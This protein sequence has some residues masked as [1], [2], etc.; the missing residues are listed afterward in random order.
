MAGIRKFLFDAGK[1]RPRFLHIR[2]RTES[3]NE[4]RIDHHMLTP[5][6]M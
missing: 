4:A 1:E 3:S 5:D 6:L 2:H